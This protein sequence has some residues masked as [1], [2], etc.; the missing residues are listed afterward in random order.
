MSIP[1]ARPYRWP[2]QLEAP[3]TGSLRRGLESR[4]QVVR[5]REEA[6]SLPVRLR[7]LLHHFRLLEIEGDGRIAADGKLR[8]AEHWQASRPGSRASVSGHARFGGRAAEAADRLGE[9]C[10]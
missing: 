9:D 10:A 8:R 4:L 2:G 1:E 5:R 3:I 7:P 6:S